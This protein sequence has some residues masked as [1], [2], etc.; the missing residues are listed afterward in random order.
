MCILVEI[1]RLGVHTVVYSCVIL[2]FFNMDRWVGK[3]A[4]VTGASAGIGAAI[5]VDLA[6]AGIITVGLARREHRIDEL[7]DKLPDKAKA[8]LHSFKCDISQEADIKAAFAWVEEKFGGTDI[9]INNAGIFKETNLTDADNS[10]IIKQT[11]D[12]NVLGVV[13]ATREAFLQ[14]Q[15]RNVAGHVVMIN[16]VSGHYVPYFVGT[17][18]SLNIYQPSKHAVTAMTEVLRQ[19]FQRKGNL[20]K[21]TV[22]IIL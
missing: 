12:V 11:L 7:R 8:L 20:V 18:D 3:V 16:S 13:F 4:V 2:H 1:R 14:M 10:E 21:I 9:L 22:S 17:R 15:K 19:E 5:A 6:K